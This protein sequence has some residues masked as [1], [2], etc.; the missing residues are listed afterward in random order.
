MSLLICFGKYGGFHGTAHADAW[1]ICLG[2]VGITVFWYDA[3]D[4]L[5]KNLNLKTEGDTSTK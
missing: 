2:W 1:H 3:E 4:A 5:A